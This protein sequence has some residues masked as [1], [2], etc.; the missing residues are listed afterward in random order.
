MLR[1][2][3]PLILSTAAFVVSSYAANVWLGRHLGPADYGVLGVV[4]S[5]ISAFNVMQVSGVPQAMSKFIAEDTDHGDDILAAGLKLQ[6]LL[7]AVLMV[8]F[9]GVGPLLARLFHDPA[10]TGYMLVAAFVLPGYALFTA[11]GGYYNGLH[12]FGRQ[13]RINATYAVAKV[14]LIIG[15]AIQFGLVGALLGY[16]I[17]PVVALITGLHQ[18][19]RTYTFDVRKLVRLSAPLV[20]FAGLSLLQYSVDLFTVKAVVHAKATAGYYVAAQSIAIIPFLGLAA[21][22][23]VLLP[24]V[25]RL[26]AEGR[27]DDAAAA[28]AQMVR[29]L[30]MLLLPATALIAGSAPALVRLLFGHAYVP[31]AP[32]LRLL[33]T[34]YIAVTAFA[35]FASVLNGAGRATTAMRLAGVALIVT[36]VLCVVLVPPFKLLGAAASTGV[37]ALV[38]TIGAAITTRRMLAFRISALSLARIALASTV[39]LALAWLPVPPALLPLSWLGLALLY[40]VLLM[41][42]GEISAHE[43]QQALAMVPARLR[44]RSPL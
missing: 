11:F 16:A 44:R 13:A 41:V 29:Y 10:I 36:F 30:L 4:T 9:A 7:S 17:S 28:V 5:L 14:A 38:A 40:A 21:L 23:Q 18:P 43:R 26:L 3:L 42:G 24:S 12:R 39:V 22:G 33:V 34:G 20:V 1:R 37:G 25:S 15:L 31:A 2:T 32:S 6:L 35:L 19:H 27:R 8:V